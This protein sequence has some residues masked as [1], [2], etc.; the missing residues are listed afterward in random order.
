MS[1]CNAV[2]YFHHMMQIKRKAEEPQI[3]VESAY[4]TCVVCGEFFEVQET[5]DMYEHLFKQHKLEF[6]KAM[7]SL[8][9]QS[10]YTAVDIKNAKFVKGEVNDVT[11]IQHYMSKPI[12]LVHGH[13]KMKIVKKVRDIFGNCKES[14]V[15]EDD[16]VFN[17]LL[18]SAEMYPGEEIPL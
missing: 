2:R 3:P 8:S 4:V 10:V 9:D 18:V 12:S 5:V 1:N 13:T 7:T 16:I 14:H 17:H 11:F 15:F 6:A